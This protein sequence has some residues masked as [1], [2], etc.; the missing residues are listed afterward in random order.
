MTRLN[1]LAAHRG[2]ARTAARF[3]NAL[4]ADRQT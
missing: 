4:K 2:D 1:G 3:L